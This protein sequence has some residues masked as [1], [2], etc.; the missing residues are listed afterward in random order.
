MEY[1]EEELKRLARRNESAIFDDYDRAYIMRKRLGLTQ[2]QLAREMGIS[3]VTVIKREKHRKGD[4][5]S[6]LR[7]L[8]QRVGE[9]KSTQ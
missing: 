7:W 9:G 6:H 4:I 8:S 3:H 2:R 5:K 1:S